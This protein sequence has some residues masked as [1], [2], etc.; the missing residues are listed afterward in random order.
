[1][2]DYGDLSTYR[3]TPG[4]TPSKKYTKYASM[5]A[6]A[7]HARKSQDDILTSMYATYRG[8]FLQ[9]WYDQDTDSIDVNVTF[10]HTKVLESLLYYQDPYF[11]VRPSGSAL[12]APSALLIE[13]L[14]NRIWKVENTGRQ[15]RRAIVDASLT[16]LGWGAVGFANYHDPNLMYRRDRIWARRVSPLDMFTEG[17]IEEYDDATWYARR[18]LYSIRWLKKLFGKSWKPDT[19]AS[20]FHRRGVRNNKSSQAVL[21]EVVDLVENELIIMSP[22]HQTI[23]YKTPY[24]YTY[25]DGPMYTPLTFAE[26]PERLQPISIEGVTD[27]Q[28]QELNAVRTQQMRHRK[29]FNRRYLATK[30]SIDEKEM[31]K[32]EDGEDGTIALCKGD[33]R[34]VI[35]PIMDAP[36]DPGSTRDYQSD[37]KSDMREIQGINEYMS[38]SAIPRTKSAKESEMIEMGGNIRSNNLEMNVRLFML[39][40]AGNIVKVLQN[41]FDGINNI[42]KVKDDGSYHD[43]IWV[44]E[45]IAG[46][47]EIEMDIGSTLPPEPIPWEQ[48]TGPKPGTGGSPVGSNQGGGM[49]EGAAVQGEAPPGQGDAGGSM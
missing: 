12:L 38:A 23:L 17:D 6:E 3:W 37:I 8:R 43:N 16:G 24:P 11:R 1:M 10:G 44:R 9:G 25:F 45:E 5:I 36:L 41:E 22:Q 26:D 4:G 32:I 20:I 49:P 40:M 48:T 34:K 2:A 39:K 31:A 42:V 18:G 19:P 29:R 15:V 7:V 28:Q 46:D 33:P 35:V 47:Y 27:G 30:N 14:L 21:W 13:N